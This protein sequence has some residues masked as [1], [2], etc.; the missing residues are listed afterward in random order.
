MSNKLNQNLS[1]AGV[2]MI[3]MALALGCSRGKS[4]RAV[5]VRDS[6]NHQELSLPQIPDSV[7]GAEARAAFVAEHFWDELD[8]GED[9]RSLDT[10][11]IEQNFVNYLAVL[12]VTPKSVAQSAIERL[13][14][15][16]K[17]SP[18]AADLLD[19]IALRYLDDPNSPMRNEELFILFARDWS[20]D[21]SL[22]EEKRARANYRLN[23]AMKNRVGTKGNDFAFIDRNGKNTT[24]YGSLGDG[25]TLV[26]FYDPDCEQCKAVKEQ[27]MHSQINDNVKMIAI[28][29]MD[30]R[31]KWEEDKG[32]FPEEWT[33]GFATDPI[34]E[35]EIYVIRAMPTFYLFDKNGI[36]AMKDPPVEKVLWQLLKG[37]IQYENQSP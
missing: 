21:E 20:A 18:E 7:E 26:M 32:S 28:D 23:Q 35:E 9:R 37:K 6:F 3:L 5:S 31:D 30:D 29:T 14:V 36:V 4:D 33:V 17:G 10:A 13:R 11:F 22:R 25:M 34:E 8:F 2:I 16:S 15:K 12:S 24:L 19:D 27:L 1:S